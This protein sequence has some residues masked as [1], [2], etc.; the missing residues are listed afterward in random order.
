MP[1]SPDDIF[2]AIKNIVTALNTANQTSINIAGATDFSNITG[3]TI[4]KSGPG[5]IVN[6]S[7]TVAG[8]A[9]GVVYDQADFVSNRN[10]FII[11]M[12]VGIYY[13]NLPLQ[14]G[15]LVVPGAGMTVAGSYS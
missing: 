13:V 15:L 8:S 14:Y 9:V 11:P 10:I 7:V 6:I 3:S 1:A 5:R 12:T 4:I 2:T